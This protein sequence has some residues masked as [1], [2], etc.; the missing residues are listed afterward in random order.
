MRFYGLKPNESGRRLSASNGRTQRGA[1]G[2]TG[3][4]EGAKRKKRT[5]TAMR[6]DSALVPSPAVRARGESRTTHEGMNPS[7]FKSDALTTRPSCPCNQVAV[8]LSLYQSAPRRGGL[9]ADFG[10]DRGMGRRAPPVWVRGWVLES[11]PVAGVSDPARPSR[12]L[13]RQRRGWA[14]SLERLGSEHRGASRGAEAMGLECIKHT[15]RMRAAKCIS[16]PELA[17]HQKRCPNGPPRARAAPR[18]NT[19]RLFRC[20]CVW[21]P[22][23]VGEKGGS[24]Q[25][26]HAPQN[27]PKN[28]KKH[29]SLE[30]L[31]G[32]MR[33]ALKPHHRRALNQ[34][35]YP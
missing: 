21:P 35:P 31:T 25:C 29:P 15:P 12:G 18:K 1:L 26:A 13:R 14:A 34:G 27:K 20:L 33:A 23:A 5:T 3:L 24:K 11:R 28:K 8:Y 2:W 16:R 17:L 19:T 9:R 10:R 6:F 22:I 4:K 7:D 30:S 32:R